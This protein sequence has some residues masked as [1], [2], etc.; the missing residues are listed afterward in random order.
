MRSSRMTWVGSKP[1]SGVRIGDTQGKDR[2]RK[3]RPWR[4][5]AETGG[6]GE[7][8]AA[9]AEEHLETRS[10]KKQG[11]LEPSEGTRPC[12][13]DTLILNFWPSGVNVF[14]FIRF[15]SPC[16]WPS[17]LAAPGN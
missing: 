5:E 17:V 7:G 14:A 10:W 4:M 11:P 8:R 16:S 3:K 13:A 12:H 9:T 6:R 1:R 15:H 2:R